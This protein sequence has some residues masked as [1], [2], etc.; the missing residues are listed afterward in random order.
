[1]QAALDASLAAEGRYRP[2]Q[3]GV[4]QSVGPIPDCND[5][6]F[7]HN[8]PCHSLVFSPNTSAAVQ[9]GMRRG[10]RAAGS[11]SGGSGLWRSPRSAQNA[12]LW[13]ACARGR[14]AGRQ[15]TLPPLQCTSN[16]LISPSGAHPPTTPPPTH[17]QNRPSSSACAR[18]TRRRSQRPRSSASGAGPRRRR[19]WRQTGRPRSARCTLWRGQRGGWTTYS[20]A[21]RRW[22]ADV[23]RAAAAG[24]VSA[25][26][27]LALSLWC[28]VVW[29]GVVV[30]ALPWL[31]HEGCRVC[32]D[33]AARA[34]RRSA[35][36]VGLICGC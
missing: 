15:H 17:P 3:R 28:G 4:R 29:G 18:A 12:L 30:A 16:T 26:A 10:A 11:S 14:R 27:S 22:A 7:I 35:A 21:A 9:V 1:M 36:R 19:S 20:R 23:G 5:D 6:L 24:R 2:V 32:R 13:R 33:R 8:R 31:G 34:M 25:A